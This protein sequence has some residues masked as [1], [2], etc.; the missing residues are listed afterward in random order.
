[1]KDISIK[2]AGKGDLAAVTALAEKLFS[3]GDALEAEMAL[4]LENAGA[5]VFLCFSGDV[6]VGFAQVQLRRDYV[7]GTSTSPVG[8][9]EGIFVEEAFRRRGIAARLLAVS[10]DWAKEMDAIE[11]AS[12]CELA[13]AESILFHKTAGFLEANRLVCFVKSLC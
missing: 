2:K 10:E 5:A 7:E 3:P 6:P 13:N 9:L 1:M 4:L 12:D 11:F 8:Y